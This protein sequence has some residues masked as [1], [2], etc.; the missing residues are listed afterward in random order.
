MA[1]PGKIGDLHCEL[2]LSL[3]SGMR[4]M[5]GQLFQ[6]T[7]GLGLPQPQLEAFKGQ[8]RTITTS[9]WSSYEAELKRRLTT[10]TQE[11]QNEHPS[12]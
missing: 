4:R 9:F 1:E 10:F 5:R 12:P 11:T 2:D 6:A 7:E 8:I 3:T